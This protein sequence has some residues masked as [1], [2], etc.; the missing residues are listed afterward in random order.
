MIKYG[1]VI[2]TGGRILI[3]LMC[4][5]TMTWMLWLTAGALVNGRKREK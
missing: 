1:M 5:V 4:N 2:L 3:G